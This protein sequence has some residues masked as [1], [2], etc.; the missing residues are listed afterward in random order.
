MVK[1]MELD[2]LASQVGK[3]HGSHG[4]I[5]WIRRTMCDDSDNA[6]C[7]DDADDI[8]GKGPADRATEDG[9]AVMPVEC[10][11]ICLPSVISLELCKLA[12]ADDL[13]QQEIQLRI[14]Q[15]NDALHELRLSLVDKAILFCTRVQNS[16]SQHS[17]GHAWD[18]VT[19]VQ[20]V[21]HCHGAVYC[22]TRTQ[23]EAP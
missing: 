14:G 5:S 23:L 21:V 13:I 18:K 1:V 3:H 12:N 22:C 7:V 20:N 15:A 19:G 2:L 8:F 17:K 9:L 10:V 4:S 6:D 11:F 16:K